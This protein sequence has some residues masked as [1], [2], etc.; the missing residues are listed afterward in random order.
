MKIAQQNKEWFVADFETTGL[1]EY[2]ETGR[3]RVWLYSICDS[4]GTIV[5]DGDCI[6]KFMD[7]CYRHH[8]ALIYFHN[9]KFDGTFILDW[10]LRN[11][12][13]YRESLKSHD[14]QGF[15]TL[16]G[17]LGEFYQMKINFSSNHQVIFYDSLKLIPMTVKNIAKAFELPIEKEVIDYNDY[18][19]TPAKLSYVHNDVRIVAMALKFFRDK[20][21]YKMTIGSNSYKSY[22]DSNPYFKQL[23][24]RL[25]ISLINNFRLAYRGG[26][27]Q[28]NPEYA[29]KKL[30]N[31]HRYDIN[32]MY[33]SI[34]AH[35]ALPY[36][37]P[38]ECI[39][40]GKYRFEIYNIRIIFKLKEGHL[41]TLLKNSSIYNKAGETYYTDSGTILDLWISNIDLDI[42]KR[43]YDIY[44]L[45]YVK[46][47]GF[48]TAR[49][50]F[51]KWVDEHYKAKS[52]STGGLRLVYKL[53]LNS[54]YGKFGSKPTGRN[55]IPYMEDDTLKY[56]LSEEHD[57][58]IYYIPVAIAIVSYAHMLIDDAIC[59]V[60]VDNFVYCDTDS[61]HTFVELPSDVVDNKELGKFKLEGIEEI[62]KYIRQK[63]YIYKEYNSKKGKYIWEIAC[64]G[65]ATG[66]KEFLLKEYGD[67]VIDEFKLGLHVD[68]DTPHMEYKYMKLLPKQVPGGT[69]L[70]PTPFSLL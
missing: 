23:F 60:G 4:T 62:S 13:T 17:D 19:I 5:E 28:V 11:G 18:T 58:G 70:K 49:G 21:Y 59:M 51:K 25:D 52:E 34:M 33:P 61:V 6:D 47:Y 20:G 14:V 35:Q 26:R 55:K 63:T 50:L 8:G 27:T 43:H 48:K 29:G 32:S 54:L 16:I 10:L 45:E 42:M 44:H 53:T 36:G 40:P 56:K 64:A 67:N 46:I 15:S 69:I 41:P 9:L 31:I 24:P 37:K 66:I 22:I 3:T 65:M 12:Y 57:M 1:N 38:I 30:S 68:M 2:E 7:W 39:S